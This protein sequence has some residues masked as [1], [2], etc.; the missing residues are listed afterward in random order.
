MTTSALLNAAERTLAAVGIDTARLDAEVLLAETIST[1][2][3]GLYARLR[4][5]ISD[6]VRQRFEERVTRRAQ[7]EPLAY[8]VGRKEF[9]SLDFAVSPAVLIPRPETEHLIE[10]TVGFLRDHPSP[11][12]CDVGTGSGCIAVA[13]AHAL[14]TARVVAVDISTPALRLARGNAERHDVGDR[15]HFVAGD[16]LRP[17]GNAGGF[18]A[19]VSNPPYLRPHDGRSPELDWEPQSALTAG[20][21][22]LSAIRALVATA[23]AMLE[24]GGMLAVEIGAGQSADAVALAR[25]AGLES[26]SVNPDLAGIPRV[27][28]GYR[29]DNGSR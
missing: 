29:G 2:R 19:I 3:A 23:P 7:R 27:L 22:G 21:D 24:K 26:V 6:A 20:D 11:R 9:Y 17:L 15:I 5:P 18:A 4:D 16:L 28:V 12:I 14:P 25:A 1:N 13:L 10:T 8:I